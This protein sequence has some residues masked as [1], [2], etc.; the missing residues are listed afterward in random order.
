M[1]ET[2]KRLSIELKSNLRNIPEKTRTSIEVTSHVGNIFT[3][4]VTLIDSETN[5]KRINTEN[6]SSIS[7]EPVSLPEMKIVL[8]ML[9][10]INPAMPRAKYRFLINVE[11]CKFAL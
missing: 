6:D 10:A 2:G 11:I 3:L 4:D 9:N 8:S 1:L 5:R 7:V